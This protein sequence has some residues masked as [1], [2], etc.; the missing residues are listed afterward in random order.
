[1]FNVTYA[2]DVVFFKEIVQLGQNR[3]MM[4]TDH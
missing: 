3:D 1:M 2:K 4:T